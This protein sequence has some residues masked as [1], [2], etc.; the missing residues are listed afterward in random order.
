MINILKKEAIRYFVD[1]DKKLFDAIYMNG[2]NRIKCKI[3]K[4]NKKIPYIYIY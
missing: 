2:Q 3:Y 1:S 4:C